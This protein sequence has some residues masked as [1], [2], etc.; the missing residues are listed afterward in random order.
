[1]VNGFKVHAMRKYKQDYAIVRRLC[2]AFGIAAGSLFLP[3]CF[4]AAAGSV[5]AQDASPK[6]TLQP[7]L[8]SIPADTQKVNVLL[9]KGR[10]ALD[11]SRTDS[12]GLYFM[13]A[14]TL[15][16]S[17]NFLRGRHR[18]LIGIG[19]TLLVQQRFDSVQVTLQQL[20]ALNP[21]PSVRRRAQ[22]LL[23]TAYRYQGE[24]QR[25]IE[26]YK[27]VLSSIDTTRKVRTAAGV[28]MNMADAYMNLG[29]TAE[30][31][32][33][34]DKAI[35]YVEATRDS[36]F[37][38]TA[39]NNVGNAY[40]SEKKYERAGYYLERSLK[41]SRML[42]FKA[43]ELRALLNLGNTRSGEAKYAVAESLYNQAL[44]LSKQIRPNAPPIQIQYNLGELYNRMEKYTEAEQYFRQSL[45]N[46]RKA[47]LPQG[48]YYNMS[49]LGNI[50][51]AE[52]AIAEALNWH[53]RALAIADTLQ[54]PS[55]MKQTHE[56]LYELYKRQEQYKKAL[57]HLEATRSLSDSL[58]SKRREQMIAKYQT[59]LDMER[60][61][62]MNRAL[63][64]E[65]ESQLA[66]LKLQYW[67]MGV[68]LVMIVVVVVFAAFVYRSNR[69]KNRMN[70]K[71]KSQKKEL[72]DV[73][74]VQKK[75][76]GLV[77]HDLRSPLGALIGM[78]DL[79]RSDGLSQK[80]IR[81][82]TAELE[83]SLQQ[84]VNV[85]EN[86]LA[87]ARK[88]MAGLSVNPETIN[89]RKIVDVIIEG[90]K[91]NAQNKSVLLRSEVPEDLYIEAD[92]NMLKLVLRN[93]VSNGIKFAR[94]GDEVVIDA[95]IQDEQVRFTIRDTGV[96][97]SRDVQQKIFRE[98][99]Q[100]QYGTRNERGSGM[101]LRLCREFI[102]RQG[103]TISF[104]SE[105]GQGTTFYFTLPVGK[106]HMTLNTD[107]VNKAGSI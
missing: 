87:W 7:D 34:Y 18:A 70:R 27:Q 14:A 30:A 15:G 107:L 48:L 68:G 35:S 4:M 57:D 94:A 10:E 77:A 66:R 23:A 67:L 6:P 52:G 93:L 55:F 3:L 31:F 103:G 5:R 33:N 58:N 59:Q 45:A 83:L 86:L 80:E 62:Q 22:N 74:E 100:S 42:D 29:Y 56:K 72:E 28:S 95:A 43:G 41:I 16:D 61:N 97:M 90:H 40:N 46:S 2:S 71:L 99:I 65:K 21:E 39:L 26:L 44:S 85:M 36:M 92:Y 11:H 73:N 84:N 96:G 105:E 19:E 37:L 69:E 79:I 63:E 53:T 104:E 64:A 76:F 50:S 78:L 8:T 106:P 38:A 101:G 17:L 9:K 89:A 1:M 25:A 13:R 81:N 88:Q 98:Q 24:N 51:E 49:G 82:M 20:L 102:E 54:N 32:K 75:L 60:K 47:G 12:A 91:F